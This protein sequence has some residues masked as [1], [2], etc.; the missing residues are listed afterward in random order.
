[1]ASC[2]VLTNTAPV[3]QLYTAGDQ[4]RG[5]ELYL[6]GSPSTYGIARLTL[7]EAGTSTTTTSSSYMSFTFG[8][9]VGGGLG[10]GILQLYTYPTYNSLPATYG[11]QIVQVAPKI[12]YTTGTAPNNATPTLSTNLLP[13]IWNMVSSAQSGI[14]TIAASS[15][16][17]A[18]ILNT[19]VS[20]ST[21]I[22]MITPLY[23]S[24]ATLPANVATAAAQ[25]YA[26]ITDGASFVITMNTA[27]TTS[28][29]RFAWFIVRY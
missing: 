10:E 18:A 20:A 13:P 4:L 19:S 26:V 7:A 27:P 9:E 14:A 29:A 11:F 5:G 24:T 2:S 3:P 16:S 6:D 15:L 23:G 8:S 21:T 28:P 12:G 17:S 25:A 1:M 22:I